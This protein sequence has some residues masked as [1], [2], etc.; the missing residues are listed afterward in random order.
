MAEQPAPGGNKELTGTKEQREITKLRNIQGLHGLRDQ[1]ECKPK[2]KEGSLAEA[3]TAANKE[4][5]FLL[6]NLLLA[7][8]F[9]NFPIPSERKTPSQNE[10]FRAVKHKWLFQWH[11][12][13]QR[14]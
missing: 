4:I 10:P 6:H 14:T 5:I 1:S 8:S 9:M 12:Q 11:K 13:V 3:G 7:C 2:G